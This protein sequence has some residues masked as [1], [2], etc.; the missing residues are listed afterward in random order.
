MDP[1]NVNTQLDSPNHDDSEK[2]Q[3]LPTPHILIRMISNRNSTELTIQLESISSHHPMTVT[4]LLDSGATGLFIDADFVQAKNLTVQKLP[5]SMP[6]YNID[7]SLNNH[8]SIKETVDLILR[9]QDHT[10]RATFHVM[11][12]G[13]VPV[14]LGHP[15]LS[16]HNPQVN[17]KTGEVIMSRCPSEC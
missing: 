15:W 1:D 11:A 13:G 17:W 6:I 4:A 16:Q 14:I 9:Y 12:L 8:G 10:E 2:P 7:G 3:D 5:Q